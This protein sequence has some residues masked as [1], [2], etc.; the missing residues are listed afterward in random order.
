MALQEKI[1]P[2]KNKI[3]TD[4]AYGNF[5]ILLLSLNFSRLFLSIALVRDQIDILLVDHLLGLLLINILL[6]KGGLY[7]RGH[8]II[9]VLWL[10]FRRL[11]LNLRS[12]AS[13]SKLIFSMRIL[14]FVTMI[15]LAFL[16]TETDGGF[17]VFTC[18]QLL[19]TMCK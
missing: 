14:A 6:L 19:L 5:F 15:A 13:L 3:L 2:E 10:I 17:I 8:M 18:S 4:L 12:L 7:L 16:V 9:V 1:K 11:I